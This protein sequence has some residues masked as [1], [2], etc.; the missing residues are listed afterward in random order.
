MD[1]AR[2]E[3]LIEWLGPKWPN[4]EMVM[5]INK[6]SQSEV[7]VLINR[8]SADNIPLATVQKAINGYERYYNRKL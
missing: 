1:Q 7:K 2:Y 6:I 8:M 3:K 5:Y 4:F